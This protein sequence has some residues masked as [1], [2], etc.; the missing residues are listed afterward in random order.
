MVY[1]LILIKEYNLFTWEKRYIVYWKNPFISNYY[2]ELLSN[3]SLV[4]YCI[5]YYITLVNYLQMFHLKRAK[6]FATLSIMNTTF[7]C[8]IVLF[9]LRN[10]FILY[11]IS[12]HCFPFIETDS[13]YFN[14]SLYK[15][16]WCITCRIEYCD[17]TRRR[18]VTQESAKFSV[19]QIKF[20]DQLFLEMQWNI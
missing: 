16:C 9:L 4:Y 10:F 12:K 5:D 19:S 8:I 7:E 3:Y 14:T 20:K 13:F 17:I 18:N 1:F 11:D 6:F 15:L 2:F